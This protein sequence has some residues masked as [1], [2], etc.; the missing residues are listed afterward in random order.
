V[1]NSSAL[2]E[3]YKFFCA[4]DYLNHFFSWW[5]VEDDFLFNFLHA[6]FESIEPKESLID[7]GAGPTI[8]QLISARN[9]INH[10]TCAEYLQENLEEIKKWRDADPDAFNWDRH[11]QYCLSLEKQAY[12]KS[13]AEMKRSLRSKLKEF[14]FC[15]LTKVPPIPGSSKTFDVV[16]AHF[17][18]E[19]ISKNDTELEASFQKLT[20]LIAP[21]G[22]LIMSFVRNANKYDVGNLAFYIYQLDEDKCSSI[23]EKTGY[24]ILDI[25][26]GPDE[27][28][29]LYGTFALFAQRL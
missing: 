5:S 9:K 27:P 6:A 18:V 23:V 3:D 28:H 26:T 11:F 1:D 22:Y 21:N 10:I 19:C 14:V 29:G 12:S 13:I 7:V 15:D 2:V 24:K 20:S 17:L 16:T 25:M 4:K 8:Y